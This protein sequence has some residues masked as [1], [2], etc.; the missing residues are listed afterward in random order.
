MDTRGES[1][2]DHFESHLLLHG[3][4]HKDKSKA[5]LEGRPSL[6]KDQMMNQ[7]NRIFFSVL[8]K[9]QNRVKITKS[10]PS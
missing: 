1:P 10:K 5:I 8:V 4:I 6:I 7:E 2:L 3:F 9:E